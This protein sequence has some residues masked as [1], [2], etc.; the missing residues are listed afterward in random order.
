MEDGY[1]QAMNGKAAHR[2][3]DAKRLL[4]CTELDVLTKLSSWRKRSHFCHANALS[5]QWFLT[6]EWRG[7]K[8]R[9]LWSE[10]IEHGSQ[11]QK[12]SLEASLHQSL[13]L[14]HLC[15]DIITKMLTQ[16]E[17]T[18]KADVPKLGRSMVN[19]DVFKEVTMVPLAALDYFKGLRQK[20]SQSWLMLPAGSKLARRLLV[21]GERGL[22]HVFLAHYDQVGRS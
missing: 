19:T 15:A 6:S 16:T 14:Q 3:Y 21:D 8:N 4:C 10:I 17:V 1:I 11:K 13:S 2:F 12:Q 7:L 5:Q 9:T 22:R 18:R 20:H